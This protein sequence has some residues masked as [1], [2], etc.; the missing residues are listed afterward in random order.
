MRRATGDT[1]RHCRLVYVS[2]EFIAG[3]VTG[4]GWRVI[5]G[6]PE[7]CRVAGVTWVS[8]RFCF[9]V[10]LEHES[11]DAIPEGEMLPSHP[12]PVMEAV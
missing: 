8:E 4:K 5:E 2:G 10:C 12:G 1:G 3:L 11:F 6:L 9:A 7:R